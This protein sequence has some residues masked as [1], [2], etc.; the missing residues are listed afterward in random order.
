MTKTQIQ[1]GLLNKVAK[2]KPNPD[3]ITGV[4]YSESKPVY[5]QLVNNGCIGRK[6]DNDKKKGIKVP[7]LTEKGEELL[8]ATSQKKAATPSK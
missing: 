2:G 8:K 3:A 1:K 6:W 4:P 5:D 7:C